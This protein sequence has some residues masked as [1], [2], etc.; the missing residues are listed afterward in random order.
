MD[1]VAAVTFEVEHLQDRDA[2][3]LTTFFTSPTS[4]ECTNKLSANTGSYCADA[5]EKGEAKPLTTSTIDMVGVPFNRQS[6]RIER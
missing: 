2:G 5:L 3:I 6:P 1:A 4:P